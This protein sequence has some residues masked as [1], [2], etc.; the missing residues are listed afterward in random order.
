M[1][2]SAGFPSWSSSRRWLCHMEAVDWRR[3]S[4]HIHSAKSKMWKRV[5][6]T[7][8]PKSTKQHWFLL[9][10]QTRLTRSFSPSLPC[11]WPRWCG[12]GSRPSP[13]TSS[14]SS[15]L[16]LRQPG[17]EGQ[18]QPTEQTLSRDTRHARPQTYHQLTSCWWLTGSIPLWMDSRSDILS[19][20]PE[21][22][23]SGLI[24]TKHWPWE[25]STGDDDTLNW[26]TTD[27]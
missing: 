2:R 26:R 14:C 15:S 9:I 19:L 11:N 13:C 25:H 5:R 10:L 24:A 3:F 1:R 27:G 12:R 20:N 6:L 17:Q 21:A 4:S 8:S 16:D 22:K 18:G 23:L 7:R